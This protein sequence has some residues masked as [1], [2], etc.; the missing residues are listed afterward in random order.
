MSELGKQIGIRHLAEAE[1]PAVRDPEEAKLG[2][3]DDGRHAPLG[4]HGPRPENLRLRD[5]RRTE[6]DQRTGRRG[7]G[8]LRRPFPQ[9]HMPGERGGVLGEE[10]E[11]VKNLLILQFGE[12]ARLVDRPLAEPAARTPSATDE[13]EDNDKSESPEAHIPTPETP[14]PPVAPILRLVS[15][16]AV[17]RHEPQFRPLK[18]GPVRSPGQSPRPC[19]RPGYGG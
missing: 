1:R 16:G 9:V 17:M 13:D 5:R 7:V 12:C 6:V 19:V 18:D 15:V 11:I 3:V 4:D 14:C 8:D 10:G 2:G